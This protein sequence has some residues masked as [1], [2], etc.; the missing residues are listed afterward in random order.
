MYPPFDIRQLAYFVAV[1]EA[2]Q[3][4]RAAADLHIAQPALSQT[5]AKLEAAVGVRLL[6]RHP[7]GVSLTPAGEA[8]IEKARTAVRAAE[9]AASIVG[10][11]TRAGETLVVGFT[12]SFQQLAR[13][14]IGSFVASHP[15][16]EVSLRKLHPSE[17]LRE[18]RAG[19]I[20]VEMVPAPP[21]EDPDLAALTVL[22]SPRYVL[23]P[24][25]HALANEHSIVFDQIAA[26]TSLWQHPRLSAE[27]SN[28]TWMNNRRGH[29]RPVAEETQP[30]LEE[31]CGLVY[32]GEAVSVPG[33]MVLSVKGDGV[34]AVLLSDVEPLDVALV[35]R[36]DDERAT[37]IDLFGIAAEHVAGAGRE[38]LL[39]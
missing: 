21:V 32:A 14:I 25:D 10:P 23:L 5:I 31:V 2:G 20:D 36:R 16:V 29:E 38:G 19:T 12:P 39:A 30:T 28:A 13:P 1:A 18:L 8:F 17:R 27:W 4:T 22:S 3:I 37:V 24:E 15:D 33:F 7:R 35:R 26:E 34:R 9:E 6:E 11:W